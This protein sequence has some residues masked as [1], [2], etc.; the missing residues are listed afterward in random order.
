MNARRGRRGYVLQP[1]AAKGSTKTVKLLLDHG[2]D[3]NGW[4][5]GFTALHRATWQRHK[6]V[7]RVLVEYGADVNA[8]NKRWGTAL[9]QALDSIDATGFADIMTVSVLLQHGADVNAQ[10]GLYGTAL[11]AAAIYRQEEIVELLLKYGADV[12]AQGGIYG[13]ALQAAATATKSL[14][15][16][17]LAH[18]AKVNI[19]CGK[20]G[21]ALQAAMVEGN[22]EI[23]IIL[24]EHGADVNAQGGK[25]GTALQAAASAPSLWTMADPRD[26]TKLLL[27]YG[28]DVNAQGG[29]Y[30]GA[31]QAA[32][33]TG[34]KD[35]ENLLRKY[36]ATM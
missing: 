20:Y 5:G 16:L 36:G 6:D 2:T 7:I 25:Y 30:G 18:G 23:A 9:H 22:K 28:A 34:R 13:T 29:Q 3:P 32:I 19:K 4:Y 21:T 31:L 17:L 15:A 33:S 14:V 11:Q 1:A 12:N 8:Q 27:D 35:I 10:G 24:L 26:A